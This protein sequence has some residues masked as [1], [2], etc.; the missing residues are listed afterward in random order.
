MDTSEY[1][2]IWVDCK[3]LKCRLGSQPSVGSPITVLPFETNA[4]API[5]GSVF[6]PSKA[7]P[8]CDFAVVDS[9]GNRHG[10]LLSLF[11]KKTTPAIPVNDGG[12]W[13]IG[14]Q[15]KKDRFQRVVVKRF[16]FSRRLFVK[17][18]ETPEI[19]EG[20][21]VSEEEINP[22]KKVSKVKVSFDAGDKKPSLLY[23]REEYFDCEAELTGE[24]EILSAIKHL[25]KI[26]I[27]IDKPRSKSIGPITYRVTKQLQEDEFTCIEDANASLSP[28]Q[29]IVA[30]HT[31]V[32]IEWVPKP[33]EVQTAGLATPIPIKKQDPKKK[34]SIKIS[35]T[36]R[37]KSRLRVPKPKDD[38]Q[39]RSY[40]FTRIISIKRLNKEG[41]LCSNTI[42]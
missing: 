35:P 38:P 17:Y 23:L 26:P 33:P 32:E 3:L 22:H 39:T 15:E 29:R 37:A 31:H 20:R 21:V 13:L 36:K 25:V 8:K 40:S 7:D 1:C 34:S 28:D 10:L 14:L 41:V 2:W 42:N 24:T 16:P 19:K 5:A 27:D 11:E 12:K 6:K 4:F 30:D 18:L 9:R